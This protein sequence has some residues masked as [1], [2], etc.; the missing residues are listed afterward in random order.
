MNN[1]PNIDFIPRNTQHSEYDWANMDLNGERVGKARCRI[2]KDTLIIYSINIF[3][4]YE[5]HGY[6][7]FFVEESKKKF[8]V[9]IADRVRHTAVGFWEKLGFEDNHDGNYIWRANKL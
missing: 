5:G 6:G 7:K 9:I 2:E 3:P 4:E 8:S 1:E